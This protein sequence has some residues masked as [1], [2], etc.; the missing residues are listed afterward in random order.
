MNDA[1]F[2]R[3]VEDN[4][5]ILYKISSSYCR[6]AGDREDLIQEMIYQLWRSSDKYDNTQKF[7]TYMYRIALNVAI[8]F[9][10][11]ASRGGIKVALDADLHVVEEFGRDG[12]DEEVELLQQWVR[13]LGELDKA[14]MILYLEERPYREIADILG[15]TETNV[16]TKIGRLKERLKKQLLAW[17]AEGAQG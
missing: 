7:S 15:I 16:G 10:R 9:Y 4:K 11:K 2:L 5:G 14:L 3:L 17:R 6:H 12:L 8:S 1:E 13:S